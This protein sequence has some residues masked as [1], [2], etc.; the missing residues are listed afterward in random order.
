MN[1][2]ICVTPYAFYICAVLFCGIQRVMAITT[3]LQYSLEGSF[4]EGLETNNTDILCQCLR[5]YATIDKMRD[6]ENLFRQY[7]VQPHMEEV[8]IVTLVIWS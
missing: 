8:G 7:V 3:T 6:A 2:T 4:K 1:N 5:T